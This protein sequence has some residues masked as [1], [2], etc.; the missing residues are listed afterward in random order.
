MQSICSDASTWQEVRKQRDLLH[1][2]SRIASEFQLNVSVNM[3][4]SL[5][6]D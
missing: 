3:Y 2:K 4:Q 1:R 6:I 5:P